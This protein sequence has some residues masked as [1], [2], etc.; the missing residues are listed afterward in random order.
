MKKWEPLEL[1]N[2]KFMFLI[3]LVNFSLYGDNV[4][5]LSQDQSLNEQKLLYLK[6]E[7][8][9]NLR[10]LTDKKDIFP[11]KFILISLGQNC[12]VAHQI[13]HTGLNNGFFPFDWMKS[14]DFDLVINLIEN[15]FKDFL[16]IDALQIV[17]SSG[18]THIV[19]NKN[20]ALEF[21]HDFDKEKN[22]V[23]EFAEVKEKYDRRIARFYSALQA[24]KHIYFFRKNI[25]KKQ[26][27]SFCLMMEKFFK[28]TKYTLIAIDEGIECSSPWNLKNV[29]NFYYTP[30]TEIV[31]TGND[32]IWDYVFKSLDLSKNK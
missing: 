4:Q 22:I 25:T 8:Q 9:N 12:E 30:P 7:N 6:L 3:I 24:K 32:K 15:K 2:F 28:T 31:W 18:S 1:V 11:N 29:L 26:A 10:T 13:Q 5:N 23:D 19:S 14:Y 20:F 27:Q 21:V 16:K 17:D